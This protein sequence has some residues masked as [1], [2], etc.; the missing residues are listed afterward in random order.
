MRSEACSRLACA[1]NRSELV[2]TDD[3]LAGHVLREQPRRRTG[4][5]TQIDGQFARRIA[6][7]A[8]QTAELGSNT[9]ASKRRRSAATSVSPKV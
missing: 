4:A 6:E 8:E 5:T 3:A 9:R 7:R 2:E 1:S